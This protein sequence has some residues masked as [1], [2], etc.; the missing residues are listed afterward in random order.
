MFFILPKKG[1]LQLDLMTDIQQYIDDVYLYNYETNPCIRIDFLKQDNDIFLDRFISNNII[2]INITY[3]G[4]LNLGNHPNLEGY[5]VELSFDSIQVIRE[6]SDNQPYFL[7]N[8][9][10]I[11]K[12]KI[13]Y[14]KDSYELEQELNIRM[15]YFDNLLLINASLNENGQIVPIKSDKLF[16]YESG[17]L[18]LNLNECIN[19]N[20]SNYS[21]IMISTGLSINCYYFTNT[22]LIISGDIPPELAK[23]REIN[24]YNNKSMVT[25]LDSINKPPISNITGLPIPINTS[26]SNSSSIDLSKVKLTELN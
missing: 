12:A 10:K 19:I 25:R 2:T 6:L 24:L 15:M 13:I 11:N 14:V 5:I 9:T 7:S 21:R 26:G 18:Y 4:P 22:P 16:K 20:E 17:K 23:S 8:I 1:E 3:K